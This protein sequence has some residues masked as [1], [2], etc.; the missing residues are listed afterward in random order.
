MTEREE[1]LP[2]LVEAMAVRAKQLAEENELS[3]EAAILRVF[4]EMEDAGWRLKEN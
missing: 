4:E 1:L 3:P 2:W